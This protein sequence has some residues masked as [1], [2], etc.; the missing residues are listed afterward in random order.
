MVFAIGMET[1]R[2]ELVWYCLLYLTIKVR[3]SLATHEPRQVVGRSSQPVL[4]HRVSA[5]HGRMYRLNRQAKVGE[6]REVPCACVG[7]VIGNRDAA[8]FL[9]AEHR[10]AAYTPADAHSPFPA[11]VKRAKPS[12]FHRLYFDHLVDDA[13]SPQCHLIDAG[14]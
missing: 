2:L 14:C 4:T 1:F 5:E 6:L 3:A 13:S 10:R 9:L 12:R 11:G 8:D 7:V